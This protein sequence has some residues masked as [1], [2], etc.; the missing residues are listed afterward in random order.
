MKVN[1]LIALPLLIFLVQ[2]YYSQLQGKSGKENVYDIDS[3]QRT[4]GTVG[5]EPVTIKGEQ[6]LT[7]SGPSPGSGSTAERKHGMVRREQQVTSS[8]PSSSTESG[9]TVGK[10]P[11]TIKSEQQLTSSGPSSGSG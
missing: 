3:E 8:G 5:K 6:Q 9:G 7:S 2:G 4:G 11:V 1:L 10:E